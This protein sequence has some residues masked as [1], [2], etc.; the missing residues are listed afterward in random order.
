[1]NGSNVRPR[2]RNRRSL[3]S[4]FFLSALVLP[5]LVC[6][7][8]CVVERPVDHGS[9]R[10]DGIYAQEEGRT[11]KI[12]PQESLLLSFIKKRFFD[13]IDTFSF[14][15]TVGPGLRAHARVTQVFQ[16]GLGKMGA[17]EASSMG[18]SF[19]LYKLGFI[20]RE[21]GLWEE[22]SHEIGISLF[23][24]Y[25]SLGE[26]LGGNKTTFGVED[27]GFWDI[28]AAFHWFLIGAEAEVRI[29]EG[30]DF[31]FGFFGMDFMDDDEAYRDP[32]ILEGVNGTPD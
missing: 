2:S 3:L 26:S 15:I 7:A 29:D 21:G 19:P 9:E 12:E 20:K 24:F 11:R 18:Y 13:A 10:L 31:V 5:W 32:D 6:P 4:V 27:R 14:R 8:G 1:M 30:L 22:R 23:Y 25:K 17:A 28:G 16:V